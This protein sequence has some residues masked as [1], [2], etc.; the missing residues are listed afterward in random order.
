VG[1]A[2]Q[3]DRATQAGALDELAA[4]GVSD[5][6]RQ[7]IATLLGIV[8]DLDR[9][10]APLER[11]LRPLPRTDERARQLMTIPG[12]AE[13][14]GLT[15]ANEIGDVARFPSARKLVAGLAPRTKQSGQ[16]SRTGR[17]GLPRSERA[18]R[19]S[20]SRTT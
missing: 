12:V 18:S 7:S 16:S 4:H 15:I 17:R 20:T 8:D 3:P 13:L 11:E 9:Q 14:L 2:S 5:V 6:W 1:F 10:L 19:R